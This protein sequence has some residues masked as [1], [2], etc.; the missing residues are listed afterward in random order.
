MFEF[1]NKYFT[2]QLW[3]ALRLKSSNQLRMYEILKQY[4]TVGYRILTIENLKALLGIN[5]N[6]YDGRWNNFKKYVLDSCQQSLAEHTDI[7][8][9]YE[10]HGKRGKGGKILSLKFIIEKNSDYTDQIT[11]FEFIE[12]QKLKTD[13][14]NDN[15]FDDD[16]DDDNKLSAY[17]NR[18]IFLS[19]A[20]NDEFSLSEIKVLHDK[21]LELLPLNTIKKELDCYNYLTRK[22]RYMLMQN[23]KNKINN[24]F[25][26]MLSIIGK[27]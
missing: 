23:E 20:C 26:Y 8:F 15:D 19:G 24:R 21:I 1:K 11:L 7:K 10:P 27:D 4:Q 17:E 5:K 6:E 12:E 25:K 18:M 16:F 9:T 22:Y 13:T 14:S 2:Y 3:N